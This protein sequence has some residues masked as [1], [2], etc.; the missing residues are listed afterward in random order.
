MT[1]RTI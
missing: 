1:C